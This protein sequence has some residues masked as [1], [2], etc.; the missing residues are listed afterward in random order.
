MRKLSTKT[1]RGVGRSV[2]VLAPVVVAAAAVGAYAMHASHEHGPFTV[3]ASPSRLSIDAGASA[4]YR[5]SIRRR[6]DFHG[7]VWLSVRAPPRHP[8]LR[9]RVRGASRTLATVIVITSWRT[10]AGR[11]RLR[12][13]AFGG[14]FRTTISLIL[15]VRTPEVAIA[16]HVTGLE[17]GAP[18]ALNLS[19][20]NP[21]GRRLSVTRL[22]VTRQS[23]SAPWS[24]A[25]L[26]CTLADFSVRQYSGVYPLGVPRRS[27]R[28]LSSLGVPPSRQPQVLLLNRPVNQ[29][30]CERSKLT[31]AY[32]GHGVLRSPRRRKR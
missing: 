28:S 4:H 11:Y 13:R 1:A 23:V 9:I 26:P 6:A 24:T 21:Y 31:L 22:S 25:T 27:V 3:G 8:W 18:Q 29:D 17:P 14:A 2:L 10:R 15:V 16:G 19:L 30:G 7:R 32:A 20:T 12:L 5:I